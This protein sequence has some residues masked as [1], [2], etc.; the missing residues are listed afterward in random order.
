M[1]KAQFILFLAHNKIF[2][3]EILL[4]QFG[5]QISGH[6]LLHIKIASLTLCTVKKVMVIY[7]S[8]GS[9]QHDFSCSK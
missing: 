9:A 3:I 8:H 4:H 6:Y 5:T 2:G 1:L 7:F